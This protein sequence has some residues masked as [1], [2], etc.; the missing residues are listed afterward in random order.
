MLQA[1]YAA[2]DCWDALSLGQWLIWSGDIL[3]RRGHTIL[4]S[5][6]PQGWRQDGEHP[7]VRSLRPGSHERIAQ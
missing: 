1:I 3:L 6:E 7:R 2:V 5:F 4:L